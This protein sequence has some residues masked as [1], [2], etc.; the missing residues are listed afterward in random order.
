MTAES[1]HSIKPP[2][3]YSKLHY[4]ACMIQLYIKMSPVAGKMLPE[5]RSLLLGVD[6]SA[7]S[8]TDVEIR[9]IMKVMGA[10]AARR[11]GAWDAAGPTP[12]LQDSG[13]DHR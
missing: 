10:R 4:N 6:S 1:S 12:T 9:V 8:S 7:Y 11:L 3:D 2:R 13:P 5:L